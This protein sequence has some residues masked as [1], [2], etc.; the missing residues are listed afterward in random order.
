MA[1]CEYVDITPTPRVLR[2][3]GEIPF[4]PWQCV[5]E[6]ADN[7]IDAFLKAKAEGQPLSDCIVNITWSG[8]NVAYS[9]RSL[10][11][12]DNAQGMT[13]EQ[14]QNAVRAGYTSNDPVNNLGLF[15]MGFNIA[16]ARLG[17]VT[18]IMTTRSCDDEWVG[19]RL[20]YDVLME[21]KKYDVPVFHRP[22]LR[23]SEHGTR[24]AVFNLK[25]GIWDALVNKEKDIRTTLQR[26]YSPLLREE[27]LKIRVKGKELTPIVP[28]V[29]GE[30]RF[31]VRDQQR[32]P[33]IIPID[34]SLGISYFDTLRNS[35]LTDD[36]SDLI[37]NDLALG[38]QLPTHIVRRDKRIWGW[39]GVQRYANP[40]DFGIDFI[41]NGR[42]ILLGDKSFFDYENPYT[43]S[44]EL[45]YP[46]ELGSTVGGR[47]VGELHV[48]FL[49]PT[50]QKNDFD[51]TDRSWQLLV[52][53]ICG[54]GPYRPKRRK[55]LGFTEPIEA[56]LPILVNAY[57]RVDPGTKC[58]FV[59]RLVAKDLLRNFKNGVPE[60]QDD[61]L[62]FKAAQESDQESANKK[63]TTTVNVGEQPSDDVDAYF[64]GGETGT[65]VIAELPAVTKKPSKVQPEPSSTKLEVLVENSIEIV[66][67]SGKY[68]FG[69]VTPYEVTVYELKKGE[70]KVEGDSKPTFF[71]NSGINCTFV[72]NPRHN[73][74]KQYNFTPKSLL[75]QYLAEKIKVREPAKYPDLVDTYLKLAVAKMPESKIDKIALQEKAEVFFS[76]LRDAMADAF[77]NNI[78]DVI[79]CIHESGGDVEETINA[80][81]TQPELLQSFQN[82]TC[83]DLKILEYVPVKAL[84]RIIDKYP[85]FVFDEKVFR[86]L[87]LGINLSDEKSTERS[88]NEAKERIVSFLKDAVRLNAS[89]GN[90]DKNE[91]SRIQISL[92]F[93]MEAIV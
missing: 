24:I 64:V 89:V 61:S 26:I 87:Y 10:E 82:K 54:I 75:L 34:H 13:L 52:E 27:N 40:N 70:I 43:G 91:L 85:E 14:M 78:S 48:D 71:S 12:S 44:K 49:I 20:D 72:Y 25:S 77:D 6:L 37:D 23:K 15:G 55:E 7:S 73:I 39:I 11:V 65:H 18:E 53:Y 66:S 21:S 16:T 86:V 84:V 74:F 41:R 81:I 32:I 56:P 69:M 60:Y 57:N 92:D 46:T 67:L 2:I 62:W 5:A 22:K 93:L 50:Y 29:W 88:R 38:K 80:L 30:S 51:R 28:C 58:L 19:L 36:E 42:K 1:N 68:N 17:T 45:Q 33:A 31:V 63:E 3:L 76:R 35:Y 8:T 83:D 79:D 47:I 4:H 90:M 59:P 9:D